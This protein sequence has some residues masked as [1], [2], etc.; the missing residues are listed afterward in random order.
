METTSARNKRNNVYSP[1]SA[2]TGSRQGPLLSLQ[3]NIKCCQLWSTVMT[4]AI[5]I[6]S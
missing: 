1:A 4:I 2:V 5:V 6:L 3:S